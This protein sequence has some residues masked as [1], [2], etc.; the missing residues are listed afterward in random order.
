MKTPKINLKAVS[1]S[2][3]EASFST[4]TISKGQIPKI[5]NEYKS[6][7]HVDRKKCEDEVQSRLKQIE[8]KIDNWLAVEEPKNQK[9]DIE[10]KINSFLNFTPEKYR[11]SL[12]APYDDYKK[13]EENYINFKRQNNITQEPLRA[14]FK[15]WAWGFLLILFGVE[16]YANYQLFQGV[17]GSLTEKGIRTAWTLSGA[18]SFVNV[19]SGFLVGW[20]VWGKIVYAKKLSSK[21]FALTV[22]LAH[23]IIIIWMNLGIGLYRAILSSNAMGGI[24]KGF[25][26]NPDGTLSNEPN[27]VIIEAWRAYNPIEYFFYFNGQW[28]SLL[29]ALV[30]MVFAL[31]AYIDGWFS[32]DPHPQYGARSREVAKARIKLD[33][34]KEELY[35][36]WEVTVNNYNVVTDKFSKDAHAALRTWNDSVND[37]QKEFVDWK[38]AILSAEKNYTLATVTYETAFNQG[39]SK[40]SEKIL[41][42]RDPLFETEQAKPSI[43]FSDAS[44][45]YMEDSA[46]LKAFKAKKTDYVNNFNKLA[47]EWQKHQ[48]ETYSS[49]HKLVKEFDV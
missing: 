28:D 27:M 24:Q 21:L 41:L 40:S 20:L 12:K 44:E 19:F 18:Q 47:E 6:L 15:T 23:A 33:S 49:I 29:V 48:K 42:P 3:R 22:A 31:V 30:G 37:L 2:G 5:L 10:S 43:V 35:K 9:K 36:K 14:G 25:L 16:L 34:A 46:R 13:R 4:K 17:T 26:E 1:V 38:A 32:D 11:T 7:C 45:H 8:K 39:L